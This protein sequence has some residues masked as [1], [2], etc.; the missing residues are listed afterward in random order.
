MSERPVE[1]LIVDGFAGMKHV[2]LEIGRIN[3]L[4]GPESTGK[5]VC[6]KL[7]YFSK[8]L[9][10]V[11]S[12][13]SL[14]GNCT[15]N[16]EELDTLVRQKFE[17]YFPPDAW[18]SAAFQI[19]YV[20]GSQSLT[21]KH[22]S[23]SNARPEFEYSECFLT[24]YQ[25]WARERE[26]M[27]REWLSTKRPGFSEMLNATMDHLNDMVKVR[28]G[29]WAA[30]AQFFVP[31]GRSFFANLQSNPFQ[32]LS[33]NNSIDPFLVEFAKVY[34]FARKTSRL[35]PKRDDNNP[36]DV[37]RR[38]GQASASLLGGEYLCEEEEHFLLFEDT[39][40]VRVA[41]VSSGQQEL[42]PL[43]VALQ[44]I[45]GFRD[46]RIGIT[47]YVEEPEAHIFPS[48]QRRVVELMSTVFNAANTNLQLVVTTHSPYILTAFNNLIQAGEL[49]QT[50]P[51]SKLPEL[52]KIVPKEQ[53][54]APTDLNAY[55]LR[56]GGC[57]NLKDPETGL[58]AAD[59]IDSV[60]DEL[61]AQ[62]SDL[63]GLE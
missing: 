47:L 42:L 39:R 57:E 11:D 8:S 43:C 37:E 9:P 25:E 44:W 20:A 5:S 10:T 40:K 2:E 60:S 4:I 33:G 19:N 54:L 17:R 1:R 7:L 3:L 51:E 13:F 49:A 18:P 16:K 53:I 62:F 41:N 48:T 55:A 6:A 15:G 23:E 21:I 35:G 58:I 28:I 29:D 32:L 52:Y 24:L 45:A 36:A 56:D 50:L 61:A 31:A 38:I 27:R 63:L 46:G 14:Q 30:F 34:E 22:S 12:G 59:V 26:R